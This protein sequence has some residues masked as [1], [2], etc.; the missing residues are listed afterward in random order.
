MAGNKFIPIN[1]K[2]QEH[3]FWKE[4]RTYSRLEAW[5]WLIAEARFEKTEA[6]QVIGGKIV[7]WNRGECPVSLRFLAL[8]WAW[9]KNKVDNF[10]AL[11]ESEGMITK[12]TAKGTSQT[13]LTLCNY[14]TYN[15]YEKKEGQQTG[16]GRDRVGTGSGQPGDETNNNNNSNNFNNGGEPARKPSDDWPGL[17]DREAFTA[18][19]LMQLTSGKFPKDFIVAEAKDLLR[20][21]PNATQSFMFG[22]ANTLLRKLENNGGRRPMPPKPNEQSPDEYQREKERI[23]AKTRRLSED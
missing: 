14:G 3:P 20:K 18:G 22:W 17:S 7:K 5:L 16:Q 23:E 15:D 10:L 13:I 19:M 1:R 2:L 6:A 12:R 4:K 21:D 9:S 11:L 8:E